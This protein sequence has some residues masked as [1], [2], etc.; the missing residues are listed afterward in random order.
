MPE[1]IE[2]AVELRRIF[3][4]SLLACVLL[5]LSVVLDG[6][7]S[8][9]SWVLFAV[10]FLCLVYVAVAVRHLS[11]HTKSRQQPLENND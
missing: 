10:G 5:L 2:I 1:T 11:I 4:C 7:V 3:V 8:I 6:P 9:F